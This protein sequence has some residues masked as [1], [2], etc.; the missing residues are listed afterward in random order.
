MGGCIYGEKL[1]LITFLQNFVGAWA[2]PNHY[3]PSPLH[4]CAVA[5]FIMNS[6]Y[7]GTHLAE[8]TTEDRMESS[9]F[10][11]RMFPSQ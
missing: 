11:R 8:V 9:V 6:S 10:I 2:P 7:N 3:L 5:T 1:D 4:E